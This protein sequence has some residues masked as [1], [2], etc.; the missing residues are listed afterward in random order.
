MNLTLPNGGCII[1]ATTITIDLHG[2]ITCTAEVVS[3]TEITTGELKAPNG[4][5]SEAE[6]LLNRMS[7]KSYSGAVRNVR[8][9]QAAETVRME[10]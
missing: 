6:R 4:F 8:A 5:C 2:V 1:N 9:K 3:K 10:R 7:E